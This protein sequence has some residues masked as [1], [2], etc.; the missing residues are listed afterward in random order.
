MAPEKS[1][2]FLRSPVSKKTSSACTVFSVSYGKALARMEGSLDL[3]SR[4]EFVRSF[5]SAFAL[6]ASF[7]LRKYSSAPWRSTEHVDRPIGLA[8]RN[9]RHIAWC[10]DGAG[11]RF[12]ARQREARRARS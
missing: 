7:F 5:S 8:D 9:C 4:A 1:W 3:S 6:R 11:R 10:Y 2:I 12:E